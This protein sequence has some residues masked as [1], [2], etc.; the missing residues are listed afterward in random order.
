MRAAPPTSISP[1]ESPSAVSPA[2]VHLRM[3]DDALNWFEGDVFHSRENL[4]RHFKEVVYNFHARNAV[5]IAGAFNKTIEPEVSSVFQR[6]VI[7]KRM[8]LGHQL[9]SELHSE[10]LALLDFLVL[11]EAQYFVGFM[12]SS[13]SYFCQEYRMLQGKP[14]LTSYLIDIQR[15][16]DHFGEAMAVRDRA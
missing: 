13:M 2:G 9:L 14:R 11:S 4:L 6:R 1:V 8:I 3:E 5:Y 16:H 15:D 12:A 10:Q 7:T